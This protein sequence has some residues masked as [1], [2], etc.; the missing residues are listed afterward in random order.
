MS[1]INPVYISALESRDIKRYP[2]E[3][4]KIP[5]RGSLTAP[6]PEGRLSFSDIVA[7]VTADSPNVP[8]SDPA[9][10][11]SDKPVKLW[12][13]EQFG[14][15][16][17]V[18]IINPLQHIPIVATVYRHMTGDKIGLAP[19]VIGGAIWGRIGGFVSGLVNA[20]VDWFTGKDIGDHI[21]SA[22]FGTPDDSEAKPT[23]VQSTKPSSQI[24]E[25][26]TASPEQI[27]SRPEQVKSSVAPL[28]NDDEFPLATDEPQIGA[29]KEEAPVAALKLAALNSYSQG[30]ILAESTEPVSIHFSV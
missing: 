9:K 15:G 30:T 27:Q 28:N 22:L 17:I 7:D 5:E 25:I 3:I 18:D 23:V 29:W 24:S 19:R 2:T 11:K 12:E 16:D 10:A 13:K 1:S 26:S 4:A 21:Y 14:F 20:V 6:D 8:S